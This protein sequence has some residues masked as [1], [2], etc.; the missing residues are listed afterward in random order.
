LPEGRSHDEQRSSEKRGEHGDPKL[1]HP[2]LLSSPWP[3]SGRYES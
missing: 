3:M 1:S 2:F